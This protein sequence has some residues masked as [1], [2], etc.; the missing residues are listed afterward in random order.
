[1]GMMESAK[2]LKLEQAELKVLVPSECRYYIVQ[3]V[4]NSEGRTMSL[5]TKCD[6][7]GEARQAASALFEKMKD[8]FAGLT[9]GIGVIDMANPDY[10]QT[11]RFSYSK[12]KKNPSPPTTPSDLA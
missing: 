11:C 4:E 1:M 6:K 8:N 5:L 12:P 3:T 9:F 10:M 7:E 2:Q